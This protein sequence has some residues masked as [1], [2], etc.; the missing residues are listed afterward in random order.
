MS[1]SSRQ[2]D[3]GSDLVG[4]LLQEFN[5]VHQAGLAGT[6]VRVKLLDLTTSADLLSPS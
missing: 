6:M 5:S 3:D 4:W 1:L 2:H